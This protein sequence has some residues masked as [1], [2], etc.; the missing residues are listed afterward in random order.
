MF[1]KASKGATNANKWSMYSFYVLMMGIVINFVC[2][3]YVT[4][5]II[6]IDK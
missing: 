6:D 5:K 1:K 2:F 4:D 3:A